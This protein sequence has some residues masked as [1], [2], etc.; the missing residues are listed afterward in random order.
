MRRK[1]PAPV[2]QVSSPFTALVRPLASVD[3]FMTC[4]VSTS[5][6]GKYAVRY[7]EKCIGMVVSVRQIDR[8]TGIVCQIF[9]LTVIYRRK[10]KTKGSPVRTYIR[11]T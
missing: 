4:P 7:N 5:V 1:G 9:F 10:G 11:I 6:Q 2:D 8:N 3:M